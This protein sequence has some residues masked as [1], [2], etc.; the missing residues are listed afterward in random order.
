MI[1]DMMEKRCYD[2]IC[3]MNC[4]SLISW[5]SRSYVGIILYNFICPLNTYSYDCVNEYLLEIGL[6]FCIC[7][8]SIVLY[9]WWNCLPELSWDHSLKKLQ[10]GISRQSSL[11][12]GTAS[13]AV[14]YPWVF[15]FYHTAIN[16]SPDF[17]LQIY[18]SVYQQANMQP[19]IFYCL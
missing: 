7:F 6:C 11:S 3:S 14:I 4:H 19:F 16:Y 12:F 10:R 9:E 2:V 17:L 18:L 15:C 13:S 8:W 1:I 5:W